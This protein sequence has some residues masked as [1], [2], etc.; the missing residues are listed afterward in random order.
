MNT[1]LISVIVPVYN[2]EKY[3][4]RCVASILGQTYRNLELILV[5]DG[6]QDG[7]PAM[8][9]EYAARD[10]RVRVIHKANGGVSAARNDGIDAA[11]GDFVAFCDNDDF[12]A[13]NMLERLVGMCL[14][15]DCGIA[16]CR[17]T[18]GGGD[19]LTAPP[20]QPV[21]VF[22]SRQLLEN[23]YRE[24]T[25]YIWDKLYRRE[26]FR[27]VRFPAGSYTM[28]DQMVV[29]HLLWAAGRVAVTREQLYYH[30]TNPASVMNKGFDVRWAGDALNDRVRFAERENLLRLCADT[31]ARRVYEERYLLA[32][33]R[34]YNP[35]KALRAD[36]DREHRALLHRYYR[37]A[38]RTPKVGAKT[39][40]FI[41]MCRYLPFAYHTYNYAKWHSR[42]KSLRWGEIK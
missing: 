23:F 10:S 16:H 30:Y 17:F 15:N 40:L 13:P 26:V 14:D 38:A 11:K 20:A 37:E 33:N 28:E 27:D 36:F 18:K 39:K 3:L 7:S 24:A 1:P 19:F 29:H 22:T 41:F 42:N 5:D 4:K 2:A 9:D 25:I 12:Y 6:S 34:R 35:D 31:K 21:K 32:M 8:C